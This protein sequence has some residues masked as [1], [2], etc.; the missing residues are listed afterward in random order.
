MM[1]HNDF[2]YSILESSC[3][4]GLF[5]TNLCVCVLFSVNVHVHTLAFN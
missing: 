5:F 3:Y 1:F 2:H 4:F